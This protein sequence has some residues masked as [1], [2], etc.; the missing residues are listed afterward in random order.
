MLGKLYKF[1][2]G[3]ST[4]AF[5]AMLYSAG[6]Q[7][8]LLPS[9]SKTSSVELFVNF[10]SLLFMMDLVVYAVSGPLSD[11]FQRNTDGDLNV[12]KLNGRLANLSVISLF[13]TPIYFIYEIKTPVIICLSLYNFLYAHNTIRQKVI[14][15]NLKFTENLIYNIYKSWSFFVVS[16]YIIYNEVDFESVV[17]FF[18]FS[19]LMSE[20]LYFYRLNLLLK[21]NKDVNVKGV[22]I[23][24]KEIIYLFFVCLLSAL[25]QR[26]DLLVAKYVLD[27]PDIYIK[28]I[29]ILSFFINPI[30]LIMSVPLMSFLVNKNVS[31]V[32]IMDFRIILLVCFLIVILSFIA[33]FLFE[34]ISK[35][36][37][38]SDNV[39]DYQ[40]YV[41]I[42][43][44]VTL[45][46][47]LAR[48]LSVKYGCE[49]Q[50]LYINILIVSICVCGLFLLRIDDIGVFILAAAFIKLIAFS[51]GVSL[52]VL[53]NDVH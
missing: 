49:K 47:L 36:L 52:R 7:L 11:Y 43:M 22:S 12:Y 20:A 10:S 51:A 27:N 31:L 32:R 26:G 25:I 15:N 38:P 39:L 41:F 34:F 35:T 29:S 28:I 30:I 16:I 8:L 21:E 5:G 53:Q 23:N 6:R 9:I 24:H 3:A 2:S 37:Y 42:A 46:G 33:I 18:S 48:V 1:L 50:M 45:I 17:L 13:V 40:L 14:F 4:Y 44:P 19:I